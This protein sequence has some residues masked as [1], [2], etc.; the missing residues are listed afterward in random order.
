MRGPRLAGAGG[1][2]ALALLLLGAGAGPAGGEVLFREEFA[3]LGAWRPVAF[4]RIERHT[5]YSVEV[6]EATGVTR[7]R[8]EADA[9]SSGLAWRE[10]YD[11]RAWPRLR[12]RWKVANVYERADPERKDGDDYPLRV[13]VLFAYDPASAGAG[14]RIR[15][16]LAKAVRGEYPPD[17][18]VSYVWASREHPRAVLRSPYAESLLVVLRRQGTAAAGEWVEEEADVLA[19]YRA[20]FGK[21]P[22]GEATLAVMGDA[23]DTGERATAWIDWIEIRR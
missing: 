2:A 14:T 7:V 4:P 23:D 12:W 21:D 1:A 16:A 11:V 13:Y 19:D 6:E 22:P 8:V 15:Y 20:A 18:G 17:S 5:R 10:T 9:S 3:D